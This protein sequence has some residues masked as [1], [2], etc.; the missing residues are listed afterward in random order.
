MTGF[1]PEYPIRTDRLLLRPWR[2]DELDVYHRMRGDPEVVRY[3]Y[4]PP[5]R[6]DETREKLATLRSSIDEPGQWIN[7][8][9]E[10]AATGE[11]VGDVGIGWQSAVHRSAD[12]GYSF[13][14][15]HWGRGYATE[16]AAALVDQA[17]SGLAA[18]RVIGRIDSRN[19]ASAAV[20]ERLGMRLEAHLVENEW[21]KG[22]WTDESIYAVL[23]SEWAARNSAR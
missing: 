18:H 2:L 4:D 23:A 3:L 12:V 15:E 6:R 17:F 5:L 1:A 16:A 22:E 19:T 7:V 14:P 20:L 8:A 9:V 21:V 10:V 11:V 13:L